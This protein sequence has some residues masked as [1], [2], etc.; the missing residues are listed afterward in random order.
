MLN[1]IRWAD[2]ETMGQEFLVKNPFN[3]VLWYPGGSFKSNKFI[4]TMCVIAFQM[5][6]AYILDT[7]ARLTGKKPM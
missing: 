5:A 1:P 4:N 7:A 3:N 2:I 6:P